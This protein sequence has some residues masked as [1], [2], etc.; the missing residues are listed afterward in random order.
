MPGPGDIGSARSAP[1]VSPTSVPSTAT[2]DAPDKAGG[3]GKVGGLEVRAVKSSETGLASEAR[4]AAADKGSVAR[5][6]GRAVSAAAPREVELARDALP[7]LQ[8]QIALMGDPKAD[9][10]FGIW[11]QSTGHKDVVAKLQAHVNA[12]ADGD[13]KAV[14]STLQDLKR[15]LENYV[16]GSGSRTHKADMQRMLTDVNRELQHLEAGLPLSDKTEV[17]GLDESHRIKEDMAKESGAVNTVFKAR[18]SQGADAPPRVGFFKPAVASG[19]EP[20]AAKKTIGI[21][22][23]A[24]NLA[25]RTVAT[26]RVDTLLGTG[27]VPPTDFAEAQGVFGTLMDV[28]PGGAPSGQHKV[29]IT[30]SAADGARL[31]GPAAKELEAHLKA[32]RF[33][34]HSWNGDTLTLRSE[35]VIDPDEP[36]VF[37][38]QEISVGFDLGNGGVRR[39]LT[40]LQWL[41][42][43]CGQADRG[44]KNY[45][46]STETG[47]P[48]VRA[49]DNDIAFGAKSTT[50]ASLVT[51]A[52]DGLRG[53]QMPGA[54]SR[55]TYDRL[56]AMTPESL[57]SELR[58]LVAETEIDAAVAR[59]T[60]LKAHA[61]TLRG[62]GAIIESDGDWASTRVGEMLGV[63]TDGTVA[64]GRGNASYVAREIN[65]GKE[66][67]AQHAMALASPGVS[68]AIHVDVATLAAIGR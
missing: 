62:A 48:Q 23:E 24:S 25:G 34:G 54:I 14:K 1:L 8:R 19:G 51:T 60:E 16:G 58:G 4:G 20:P 9:R 33:T 67:A 22:E 27:L 36:T 39:Q 44:A 40:D 56:S 35:K 31:R 5:G 12:A 32:Q 45:F 50:C 57:R 3:A 7:G 38:P 53:A 63:R 42:L 10:L 61:E 68:A 65:Y 13:P 26:A 2:V 52:D 55:A 15:S 64:P 18:Y 28:A 17:R 47:A 30:F 66:C 37:A 11:K 46:V 49:I 21:P 43:L 6:A 59:L 29:Q 41:D